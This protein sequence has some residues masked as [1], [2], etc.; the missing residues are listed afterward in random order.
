MLNVAERVSEMRTDIC[1]F[2]KMHIINGLD[3][4]CRVGEG[5]ENKHE[6]KRH[7]RGR[8][9]TKHFRDVLL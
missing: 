7:E 4:C 9:C 6:L 8:R 1:P 2:G 5:L 3:K